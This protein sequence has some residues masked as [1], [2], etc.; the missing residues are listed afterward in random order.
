M[1][2]LP[3]GHHDGV[4][5]DIDDSGGLNISRLEFTV[6]D[7]LSDS[8]REEYLYFDFYD[9]PQRSYSHYL[10]IRRSGVFENGVDPAK[11]TSVKIL[12]V[13]NGGVEYVDSNRNYG[14]YV[15]DGGSNGNDSDSD[16]YRYEKYKF[17]DDNNS[18][19]Y[20]SLTTSKFSKYIRS[21][22]HYRFA[23][24]SNI[25]KYLAPL[26]FNI[27][28]PN[29]LYLYMDELIS[30]LSPKIDVILTN[31]SITNNTCGAIYVERSGRGGRDSY[32]MIDRTGQFILNATQNKIPITT[33][34]IIY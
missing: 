23:I 6:D 21:I 13:Y 8:S 33:V 9:P 17:L 2:K 19:T 5:F 16:Y 27:L 32:I 7:L 14:P 24:K 22:Y 18:F 11:I 20:S 34:V 15:P 10:Y 29:S 25:T 3:C 28:P 30:R 4:R 1:L 26:Y 31:I 12:D